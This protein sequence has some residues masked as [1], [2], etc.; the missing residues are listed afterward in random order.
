MSKKA[1]P[2]A[3]PPM[4]GIYPLYA[5]A[6]AEAGLS[7]FQWL[8]LL[9]MRRGGSTVCGVS[10]RINCE[11]VWNTP[12]A[13]WVHETL[14]M[15]VAALGVAWGLTAALLVFLY[16][17]AALRRY[18][19]RPAANAVRL[20]AAAGV[21]AC[22]P[23]VVAS[24]QAGA[25][26]PTC[27]VTYAL[28]GGFALVAW[29]GLPGPLLPQAGEWGR[30]ITWAGG[31]ALGAYVLLLWPGLATPRASQASLVLAKATG[32]PDT[33][34]AYIAS[35]SLQ[36]RQ[37][38]SDALAVYR[39]QQP[40]AAHAPARRRYGPPD[41][42][43]K[44]VEWTDGR[45]PHCKSLVEALAELKRRVPAGKFSLEA[46]QFPLDG[47]CN[48]LM[49]PSSSDGTGIR[50]AVARAQ[51]CLEGAPDYWE[52]REK[53][54]AVQAQL[55]PSRVMEIASSG[56]VARP[57]LEACMASPDTA[58][59][60]REDVLYAKQHH[61]EGTPLVVANGREVPA[62]APLL[63]ALAMTGGNPDAS[64]FKDLPPPQLRAPG[65]AH[66]DH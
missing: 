14:R 11:T 12:F 26:C 39:G 44:L 27:L 35:L 34:D 63:Y 9:E 24:A 5:L 30:A 8:Q 56:S 40:Q 31:A 3:A 4:R 55:T 20:T 19:V 1:N 48:P 10:E 66:D 21:L 42:P 43:L 17:R 28:V 49:P 25:L 37:F 13:A 29:K 7:I 52:L 16:H 22:V 2:H 33:L 18:A 47:Q 32:Q 23:F 41:A 15:P 58:A 65:H 38:M 53:M 46:R 60:L 64:A 57:Q 51:I 36:E 45:C 50:C 59:K 54:F 61:L 6:L 62:F